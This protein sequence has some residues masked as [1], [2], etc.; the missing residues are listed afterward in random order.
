MKVA[1][2][3]HQ[4]GKVMLGHSAEW[5]LLQGKDE[6]S[7]VVL[8]IDSFA[9]E[10]AEPGATPRAQPDGHRLYPSSV[11]EGLS[12]G[13]GPGGAS[14][15]S[16]LQAGC[17]Q[18]LSHLLPAC[19]RCSDA[20]GCCFY[21]RRT[22]AAGGQ[23][24]ETC[25]THTHPHRPQPRSP[26]ELPWESSPPKPLT[27]KKI[28]TPDIISHKC[29]FQAPSVTRHVPQSALAPGS[30]RGLLEDQND[31]TPPPTDRGYPEGSEQGGERSAHPLPPRHALD[32]P[33]WVLVQRVVP[34][35][36]LTCLGHGCCPH[37][38]ERGSWLRLRC[39]R[40]L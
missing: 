40:G 1:T 29:G 6:T 36:I 27:H 14:S 4:A 16:L 7:S 13:F 21:L 28:K 8:C 34:V 11:Q 20:T 19:S 12:R 26:S 37:G 2:A 39:R 22:P 23:R 3:S 30:W 15:A 33:G 35:T 9:G 24:D 5:A 25:L 31:F 10:D 18:P 38:H 17:W 32:P